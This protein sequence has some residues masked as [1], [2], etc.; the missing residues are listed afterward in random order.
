M[1]HGDKKLIDHLT[2]DGLTD[3]FKHISMGLCAEKTA[4]EMQITRQQQD[5][6]CKLTF[7]RHMQAVKDNH[8]KGEIVPVQVR[9][10][11]K[12][13]VVEVDEEASRYKE[14]VVSKLKPA[15]EKN[16]T[17]TGANASKINDGA[18]ALILMS[19]TKVKEM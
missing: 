3:P 15:F 16:G 14:E 10:K 8:L 11:G 18:C 13:T 4:A 1:G 7:K 6:Y 9:V 2:Y 17:I 19:A 5:D 12:D